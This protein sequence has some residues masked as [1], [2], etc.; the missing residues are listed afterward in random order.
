MEEVRDPRVADTR[1]LE[2]LR[3]GTALIRDDL[4]ATCILAHFATFVGRLVTGEDCLCVRVC[5]RVRVGT[6]APTCLLA[7]LHYV[8]RKAFR[9]FT[10]YVSNHEV[11]VLRICLAFLHMHFKSSRA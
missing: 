8:Y 10:L 6:C 3:D 9:R 5:V 4:A 1:Y 7:C 2:M 11:N